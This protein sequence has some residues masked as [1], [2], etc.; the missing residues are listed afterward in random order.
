MRTFSILSVFLLF[1]MLCFSTGCTERAQTISDSIV[2]DS[3]LVDSTTQDSIETLIEE[4]P[5][6]KAA[7]E[8][9]DDFIFNYAANRKLQ[10]ERTDFPLKVNSYGK[11]KKVE[12]RN[13]AIE[14]FFLRQGYYTL[15]F[16]TK[17]QMDI[18]KDTAIGSATVEKI[19]F[20][21]NKMQQW[22]FNRVNGL[23]RLQSMDYSSL[24]SHPD[25]EFLKFYNQFVTDTTFQISSLAEE[26]SVSAPDPD[27]DFSR[28]EGSVMPEQ[29]PAFAPWMPSG[30]L[31]NIQYGA[32]PYKNGSTRI[33]VIRGIANGLETELTFVKAGGRWQLIKMEN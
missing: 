29:W 28:M 3:I 12:N 26:V 33:F 9:F 13:W 14:R 4:T 24:D 21:E 25:A 23:W 6:P 20:Q 10:R 11:M 5:M 32:E 31:Y 22:H 30:V 15:V 7:D 16:H 2:S 27:D 1:L 17:S 8:L 18:V 19:M